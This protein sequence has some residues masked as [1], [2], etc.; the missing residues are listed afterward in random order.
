MRILILGGDG[1]L[2][3]Q[4][5]LTLSKEHNV[6][7]TL[8]QDKPAYAN[9]QYL[10]IDNNSYFGID[11]LNQDRLIEV[12]ADFQPEVIINSIGIVKQRSLAKEAIPSLE[13]N[14]LLPHKLA[15]ICKL[16]KAR[17]ICVSTDCVFTGRKGNYMEQDVP[18]AVD[19]YGRTKLLGEV[20]DVD[21]LTMRT[22]IIGLELFRK[23]GLVEWFLAQRGNINGFKRAIYSGLTTMELA[24]VINFILLTQKSLSGLYHIAS[25]PI[26]KYDLLCILKEK[27][28]RTDINIK[29]D[30]TFVCDRSLSGE[31]FSSLTGYVAPTWGEMLIELAIQIKQIER[32]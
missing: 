3:H 27:L 18:D 31:K 7:V 32:G 24:R 26:S 2:G 20:T 11:V 10:F 8:R 29:A 13:I 6:K 16:I 23:H 28:G 4:L 19:L 12:C 1:M 15:Y 21:C 9:H 25:A 30:E 14:S 5:L 17:L 22:S